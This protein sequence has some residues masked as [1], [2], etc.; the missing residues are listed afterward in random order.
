MLCQLLHKSAKAKFRIKLSVTLL[1]L[2]VVSAKMTIEFPK[3]PKTE[4]KRRLQPR[5]VGITWKNFPPCYQF[6]FS[7]LKPNCLQ[8]SFL[9]LK[10][11]F[12]LFRR[13][14][15]TCPFW[16]KKLKTRKKW[17]SVIT[18]ECRPNYLSLHMHHSMQ[19]YA[20]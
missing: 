18:A 12:N 9:W 20:A 11:F 8:N 14:T 15:L 6:F 5:R 13:F 4:M 7:Y 19:H 10:S 16:N 1:F 17:Y 3:M 2:T